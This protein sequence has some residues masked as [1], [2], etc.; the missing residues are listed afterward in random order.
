MIRRALAADVDAIIPLI[1]DHAVYENTPL[2]GLPSHDALADALFGPA[3]MLWAWVAQKSNAVVG[4]ASGSV[5][6]STWLGAKQFNLDCLYLAPDARG[7]GIG[8][9]LINAVATDARE[10]GCVVM[11]WVTPV[12][13][14]QAIGFYQAMGARGEARERFKLPLGPLGNTRGN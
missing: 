7:E 11:E 2:P 9:A 6:Y 3:L 13:N 4:Y 10:A 1:R 8:K 5:A 12:W 14:T